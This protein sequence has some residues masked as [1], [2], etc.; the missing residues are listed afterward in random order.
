[1]TIIITVCCQRM[2]DEIVSSQNSLFRRNTSSVKIDA[3]VI[4]IIIIITNF[5][6]MASF[7]VITKLLT[8][9]LQIQI[10]ITP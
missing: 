6:Q 2:Y 9:F 5:R 1:M 7:I 10:Q 3:Y 4:T 8:V